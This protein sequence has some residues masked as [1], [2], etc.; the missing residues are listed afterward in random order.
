MENQLLEIAKKIQSIAQIGLTYANSM[1][2][3]ERYA[4]LRKISFTMMSLIGNTP[5]EKI[6]GLF[7]HEKGYQTPKV[8]VRSLIFRDEAILM[9]QEKMDNCW[10]PPGGFADIGLTP[11]EIAMKECKEESGLEVEPIRLIAV[12]DKNRHNHPPSPWDIYK[13]FILCKETGGSLQAGSETLDARFFKLNELPPLS[14]ERITREQIE[15]AYTF[16][17]NP[18]K[19]VVCE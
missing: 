12:L 18:G 15:M 1:Y 10:T 17:N 5:V 2:D 11:Y 14:T 4:E 9:V 8:D 7:E 3:Q 13:L 19:M 16:K 6:H